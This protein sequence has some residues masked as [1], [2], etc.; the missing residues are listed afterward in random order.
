MNSCVFFIVHTA[1]Q[2]SNG[3]KFDEVKLVVQWFN[4]SVVQWV[5]FSQ[6]QFSVVKCVVVKFS[7]VR[8]KRYSLVW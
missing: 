5:Q 4:G 2:Q 1:L 7:R 6:V 8:I 3:E